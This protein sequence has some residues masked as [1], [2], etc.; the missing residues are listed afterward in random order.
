M[1]AKYKSDPWECFDHIRNLYG[2]IVFLQMGHFQAVLLSSLDSIK[3]V[4]LEKADIFV[5]R[6]QFH[7]YDLIFGGDR[8]NGQLRLL[9]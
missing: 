9:C 2:N 7:R 4:L 8:D 1:F 5:H 6:P 3:K